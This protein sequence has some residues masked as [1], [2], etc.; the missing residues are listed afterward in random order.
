MARL[1][2]RRFSLRLAL[3]ASR[4]VMPSVAP[5]TARGAAGAGFTTR[6]PYAVRPSMCTSS[7]HSRRCQKV[8]YG[9]GTALSAWW[10][11]SVGRACW[12]PAIAQGAVC[13]TVSWPCMQ[14]SLKAATITGLCLDVKVAVGRGA[15]DAPRCPV[16]L[17]CS[18]LLILKVSNAVDLHTSSCMRCS[19][20]AD[21]Q[22]PNQAQ[23]MAWVS[24]QPAAVQRCQA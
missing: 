1:A 8:A 18:L 3:W 16:V 17:L 23:D 22:L 12:Q 20:E 21:M 10:A 6:L 5:P 11:G 19:E 24:I 7:V 2:R 15:N 13:L 9:H 4:A 14:A